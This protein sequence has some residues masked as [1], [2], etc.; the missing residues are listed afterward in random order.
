MLETA[1]AYTPIKEQHHFLSHNIK[2]ILY[3]I[4]VYCMV[5]V[6]KY[7]YLT[8]NPSPRKHSLCNSISLLQFSSS[9]P[10]CKTQ[11]SRACFVSGQQQQIFLPLLIPTFCELLHFFSSSAAVGGAGVDAEFPIVWYVL[12]NIGCLMGPVAYQIPDIHA[13]LL[14]LSQEESIMEDDSFILFLFDGEERAKNVEAPDRRPGSRFYISFCFLFALSF[15]IL[16]IAC[17]LLR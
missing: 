15:S 13:C 4:S 6:L 10:F 2:A 5:S 3:S 7:L 8:S 11:A 9:S 1:S 17:K 12:S 16:I 14:L